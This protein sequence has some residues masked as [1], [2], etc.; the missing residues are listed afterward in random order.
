MLFRVTCSDL[1][2]SLPGGSIT[3]EQD[4][5]WQTGNLSH[6]VCP[7]WFSLC[8]W[9]VTLLALIPSAVPRTLLM[10]CLD[11]LIHGYWG[12]FHTPLFILCAVSVSF[13][14]LG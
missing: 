7:V 6:G 9:S 3:E 8:P 14:E 2:V 13:W 11:G 10:N 5:L 4:G 12:F 1:K